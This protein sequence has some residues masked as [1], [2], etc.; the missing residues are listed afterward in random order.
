[1]PNFD[2]GHYFLTTLVPVRTDR[3]LPAGRTVTSHLDN[4]LDVLSTLPTAQ[5]TEECVTFGINSP[6]ARNTRTHFARFAVIQDV[7]YNGRDPQDA[8]KTAVAGPN[9]VIPQPVDRLSCP[10]LLF[11]ADFDAATDAPG[12]LVSY[13]RGL[14]ETMEPELVAIFGNCVGFENVTDAASFATYIQRCQV[15]TTMSFN[16]YW[17]TSPPLTSISIPWLLAP[18]AITGGAMVLGLLAWPIS[19]LAGHGAGI[20]PM[21]A[22][23][24]FLGLALSLFS[25]YRRV[26]KRG[27]QPF[28]TAP[29]SNLPSVLK[30]LYLQ[31]KFTRFIIDMQGQ[32]AERLHAGF[33]EFIE[34][35]KPR[36]LVGPTQKPGVIKS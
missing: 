7:A 24:G 22:L 16:D 13:L 17:R 18:A 1:M 30:A 14:W 21:I 12:E 5:Q 3:D 34:T 20:W 4:L 35:H 33:A 27:S 6:F 8:L 32:S 36:D 2:G 19:V 11:S 23:F 25:A 9:P 10:F 29:D 26:M 15:E 31:Q 28:P